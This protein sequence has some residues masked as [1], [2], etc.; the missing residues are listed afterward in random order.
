[1]FYR[2]AGQYKTTYAGDQ[3]IFPIMQDRDFR[4][5]LAIVVAYLVVPFVANV[6]LVRSNP[7]AGPDRIRV[8]RALGL[9]VLTGYAGQISLGTG[10]FMAVGRLHHVTSWRRSTF[11]T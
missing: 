9:N 8:G 6:I 7:A 4:D 1:M 10:G 11:P 3:G 2:E 5:R